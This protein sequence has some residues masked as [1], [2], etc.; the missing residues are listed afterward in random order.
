[1]ECSNDA[2]HLSRTTNFPKNLSPG[3]TPSSSLQTQHKVDCVFLYMFLATGPEWKTSRL[4][5]FQ[6]SIHTEFPKPAVSAEQPS[7]LPSQVYWAEIFPFNC[8]TSSGHLYSFILW[9]VSSS[10]NF[11]ELVSKH[12]TSSSCNGLNSASLQCSGNSIEKP[13]CLED[14]LAEILQMSI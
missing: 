1:M 2:Q 7:S 6:L 5:M 11:A 8:H 3:Q 4:L 10:W 12:S 9:L 14:L 13:Y